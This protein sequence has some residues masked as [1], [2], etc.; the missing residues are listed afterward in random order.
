MALKASIF[1][2]ALNLSDC[3]KHI[4]DSFALTLARHPSET[5]ERMMMRLLAYVL[6]AH[7]LLRFGKGLS[8]DEEPDLWHKSLADEIVQWIDVGQPSEDRCRKASQRAQQALIYTYG[9]ARNINTWWQKIS[10][11]L[12][13]FG[14]LQV[15]AVDSEKS[16]ALADMVQPNMAIQVTIDGGEIFFSDDKQMVGIQLQPLNVQK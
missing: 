13:R 11:K 3:D 10:P 2:I 4:Y 15:W 7:E 16:L 14:N 9:T 12:A 8:N 5:D 6:N 1:K